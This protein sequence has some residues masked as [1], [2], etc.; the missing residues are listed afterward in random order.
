M[1]EPGAGR[2]LLGATRGRAFRLVLTTLVSLGSLAA[3]LW[4]AEPSH[5]VTRLR[6][7]QPVWAASACGFVGANMVL[8]GWRLQ[9]MHGS[10]RWCSPRR[11]W[12][13]TA[14][15]HQ[16]LLSTLPSGLG[17]IG[18]PVLVKRNCG[19]SLPAGARLVAVYRL[20]DVW[21]LSGL[22]AFGLLHFATR[23]T[24]RPVWFAAGLGVATVAL[25]CSDALAHAMLTRLAKC[26][27]AVS[28]MRGV[29][30][31]ASYAA[32]LLEDALEV[33]R[34]TSWGQRL[35]AVMLTLFAWTCSIGGFAC[36]F[37]MVGVSLSF[38][39]LCL[40]LGGLN[41][42]GALAGLSIAGVGVGETALTG[43]L[44]LLGFPPAEAL[45]TS[46]VVRPAALA[47]VL[48]TGLAI[49]VS[50]GERRW[51]PTAATPTG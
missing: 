32:R 49:S 28:K 50:C 15:V 40:I 23:Q 8:R 14:A 12:L 2:T 38:D 29:G 51:F 25:I 16:M 4:L 35:A 31:A 20:Q 46:L 34:A 21:V 9:L 5:L 30:A 10:D 7:I 33:Q 37:A 13:R 22:L 1:R 24:V 42:S 48:V 44:V 45:S 6:E 43:L 11:Q 47:S 36:L 41:L 18:F 17:D 27:R 3:L 19:L 26:C 39:E